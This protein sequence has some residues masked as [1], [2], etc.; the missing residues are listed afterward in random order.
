MMVDDGYG[1]ADTNKSNQDKH[2][3]KDILITTKLNINKKK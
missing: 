1:N 3:I 2:D